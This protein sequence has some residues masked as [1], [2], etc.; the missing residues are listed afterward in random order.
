MENAYILTGYFKSPNLIE[1]DEVFP[2]N[3][4]RVR[5]VIEPIA[6]QIKKNKFLDV[7]NDIYKKQESRKYVH[8]KKEDIDN[9]IKELRED[10]D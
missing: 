6:N 5:L 4:D 7:L 10:W 2:M 8:Q 9:W 3:L 1:L